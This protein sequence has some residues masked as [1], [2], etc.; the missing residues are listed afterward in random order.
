MLADARQR[1]QLLDIEDLVWTSGVEACSHRRF[2][3]REFR[4]TDHRR[5]CHLGCPG[6]VPV[7]SV[8][9]TIPARSVARTICA[10]P[11]DARSVAAGSVHARSVAT[12]PVDARSVAGSARS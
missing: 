7:W 8:S 9:T 6:T 12:W 2:A 10:W 11:I 3:Y 1:R 5:D 4:N